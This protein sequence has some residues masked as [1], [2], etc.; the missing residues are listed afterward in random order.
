[1]VILVRD[2]ECEQGLAV[3]LCGSASAL[4]FGIDDPAACVDDPSAFEETFK[5]FK[6]RKLL[7]LCVQIK[8]SSSAAGDRS[9]YLAPATDPLT[10]QPPELN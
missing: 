8:G 10:K 4:F 3:R 6:K 5:A 7:T 9:L 1:M 2:K